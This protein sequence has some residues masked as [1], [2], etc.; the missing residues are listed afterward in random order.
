MCLSV[1]QYNKE[2]REH[3]IVFLLKLFNCIINFTIKH[4]VLKNYTIL[5]VFLYI[6][7]AVTNIV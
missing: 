3:C 2:K 6:Y 5:E 7:R 4:C 1:A